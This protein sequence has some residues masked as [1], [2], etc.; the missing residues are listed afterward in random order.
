MNAN[1][2]INLNY[3][4]F[5]IL[6]I[7]II[8]IVFG[9]Y[10]SN[11]NP[12]FFNVKDTSSYIEPAKQICETGK[13]NN[14]YELPETNRLPGAI[15]HLLPAVC[16]DLNLNYYIVLLNSIMLLFSGYFTF[17]IVQM[18][19][20]KINPL[21]IFLFFLIDPTLTRY[22][23]NI[24]TEI[25][26]L[27]WFSFSIYLFMFGLIKKNYYVFFSGFIVLTISTY[28]K[29][30]IIYLPF[31][32]TTFIL[33]L[34]FFQTSFMTKFN[35][36]LLIASLVGLILHFSL[37]QIWV[38]RN[39]QKANVKEF[40]TV[41]NIN[42]YYYMTAAIVAKGEKSNWINIR[43]QFQEKSKNLTEQQFADVSKVEFK[44]ALLN[45]PLESVLVGIEG[46]VMTFF[47]PG[48]GQY[49]KGL[50]IKK[51]YSVAHNLF[52][53]YGMFWLF[54]F[55]ALSAYGFIKIKKNNLILFLV[56]IFAYLLLVSS[57]PMS[58]SRFR[59][60]FLPLLVILMSSGIENILKKIKYKI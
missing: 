1:K 51:N 48:T 31:L 12:E 59:I 45:Y 18:L 52:I 39:H 25:I 47:T 46:A 15:L 58:Y 16:L 8:K 37:T 4:F 55:Y 54:V 44:K 2:K 49:A 14:E 53:F 29:P 38:N 60:P 17:K 34:C 42:M 11:L 30:L 57:G 32:I 7:F 33:L 10:F 50:L 20:I 19:K 13:Y 3:S 5:I 26:F 27:F 9:I 22:Q 40:S 6:L 43:K 23:Y 41:K 24:L 36:Q 28:V 35:N 56:L 21:F